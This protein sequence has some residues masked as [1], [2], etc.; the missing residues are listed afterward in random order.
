MQDNSGFNWG[1]DFRG[2]GIEIDGFYF[3][4]ESLFL[5]LGVI[6]SFAGRGYCLSIF[7]GDTLF[8]PIRFHFCML[9]GKANDKSE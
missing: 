3:I 1:F 6:L 2:Y 7:W 8:W 5:V 9:E 4:A